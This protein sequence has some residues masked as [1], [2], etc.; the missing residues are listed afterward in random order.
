MSRLI[1]FAALLACIVSGCAGF[2]GQDAQ[3]ADAERFAS[4]RK[5]SEAIA[6]YDKIVKKSPHSKNQAHALFASAITRAYYDNPT[7]DYGVALQKF[8]EFLRL[9]PSDD[10]ATDA[11][12]WRTVLK[13]VLELKRE[14]EQLNK[15]IQELK[16]I[17]IR[18]E[19]RRKVN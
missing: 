12:N 17:D 2:N 1:I 8:E 5:Y 15:S 7:R 16:R 14:N 18:H 19:Q 4:D 6:I 9:Y 11:R 10:K 13:T 3:L